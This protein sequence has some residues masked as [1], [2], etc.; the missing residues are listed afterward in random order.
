MALQ[1]N[2]RSQVAVDRIREEILSGKLRGGVKIDQ[3]RLTRELKISH[4]PLR[5]ALKQ[6]EG[7]GYLEVVSYGGVYVK[8]LSR[9]EM[10]DLYMIR[11]EVESLTAALAID[12]LTRNDTKHLRGLFREMKKAT[13][14]LDY[15]RLLPLNQE[16]HYAIYRACKRQYLLQLLDD[17]W[18]QCSR[19]RIIGMFHPK[20]AR[21]GLA[22]HEAMLK[23][24]E[25]GDL[26]ALQKAVRANVD[27][28]RQY[29]LEFGH[30]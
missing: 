21:Q 23:A 4:I 2:S 20:R 9:E 18:N 10:E 28:T 26:A 25:Q 5:E 3:T 8:K 16:F 11:A 24:C 14:A 19:Y 17:L 6:L 27:N 29:L 13:Q 22:E 7:E 1:Y 30:L 15:E 12:N